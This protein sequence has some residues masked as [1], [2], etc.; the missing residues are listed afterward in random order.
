MKIKLTKVIELISQKT[1]LNKDEI[2]VKARFPYEGHAMPRGENDVR[3]FLFWEYVEMPENE[4]IL[5]TDFYHKGKKLL[6]LE[7]KGADPNHNDLHLI[8]EIGYNQACIGPG[9]YYNYPY[10]YI[11]GRHNTDEKCKQNYLKFLDSVQIETENTKIYKSEEL[12]D[13]K[14]LEDNHNREA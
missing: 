11:D 1:S 9:F 4:K 10:F 7:T 8:M 13:L 2:I 5:V 6:Q 3:S 12:K 14:S